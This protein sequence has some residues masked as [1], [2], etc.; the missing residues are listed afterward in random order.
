[1]SLY[2]CDTGFET[3]VHCAQVEVDFHGQ[4]AMAVET[5]HLSAIVMS[6]R[7]CPSCLVLL[8]LAAMVAARVDT[9]T[10]LPETVLR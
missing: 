3:Q 10:R 2:P 7:F 8:I 6:R 4:L 9:N 5:L 1:M